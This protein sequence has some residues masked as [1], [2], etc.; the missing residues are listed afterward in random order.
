M[1]IGETTIIEV[2][3]NVKTIVAKK[4]IVCRGKA[5]YPS[6]RELFYWHLPENP[7]DIELPISGWTLKKM[8][9]Y[10]LRLPHAGCDIF[11][12]DAVYISPVGFAYVMATEDFEPGERMRIQMIAPYLKERYDRIDITSQIVL[13]AKDE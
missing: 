5:V 3:E 10:H 7:F 11:C 13:S 8:F 4:A 2:A 6:G 1:R 9:N 12:M